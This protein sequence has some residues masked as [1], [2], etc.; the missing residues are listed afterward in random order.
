MTIG[1]RDGRR[2]GVSSRQLINE[3]AVKKPFLAATVTAA[4]GSQSQ[5]NL[6]G[7]NELV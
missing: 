2:K 4:V 7:E 5:R 1:G 3:C 6:R